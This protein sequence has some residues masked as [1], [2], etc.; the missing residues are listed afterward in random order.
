MDL[1]YVDCE[2]ILD[3]LHLVAEV[4]DTHQRLERA[5]REVLSYALEL[6]ANPTVVLLLFPPIFQL[7]DGFV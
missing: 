1:I 7:V 2:L 3:A 6:A 4:R 5:Y